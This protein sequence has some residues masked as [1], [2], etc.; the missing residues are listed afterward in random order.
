[1]HGR[2]GWGVTLGQAPGRAVQASVSPMCREALPLVLIA[3]WLG[4]LIGYLGLRQ[5]HSVAP[6]DS[7][8]VSSGAGGR[9]KRVGL[10]EDGSTPW[11]WSRG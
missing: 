9:A 10:G 2:T 8:C 11:G 4:S 1:M 3:V 5:T 7:C 6:P